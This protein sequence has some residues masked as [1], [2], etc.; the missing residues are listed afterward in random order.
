MNIVNVIA[1]A[2]IGGSLAWTLGRVYGEGVG[3]AKS[4]IMVGKKAGNEDIKRYI[5][6]KFDNAKFIT[7]MVFMQGI[8]NQLDNYIEALNEKHNSRG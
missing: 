2:L 3:L 5:D 6:H 8:N 4:L 7:K 1:G